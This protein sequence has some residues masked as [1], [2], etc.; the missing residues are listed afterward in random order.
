MQEWSPF[1]V[2]YNGEVF[3]EMNHAE[4]RIAWGGHAC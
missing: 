3:L 4:T 2:Y 1:S